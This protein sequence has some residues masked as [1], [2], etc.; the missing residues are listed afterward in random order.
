MAERR[1]RVDPALAEIANRNKRIVESYRSGDISGEEARARLSE[2]VVGD[3]GGCLWTLDAGGSWLFR[4]TDGEWVPGK[5]ALYA[6]RPPTPE[7]L[8]GVIMPGSDVYLAPLSL[9]IDGPLAPLAKEVLKS[10]PLSSL[11]TAIRI[12]M[13]S[14]IV[15]RARLEHF[16]DTVCSWWLAVIGKENR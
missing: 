1:G 5:P 11:F 4:N 16:K 12:I 10:G 8:G 6:L 2:L 13:M 14:D 15:V 3:L 7:E 9:F